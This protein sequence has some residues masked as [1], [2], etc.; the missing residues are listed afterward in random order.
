MAK[1][2]KTTD[3]GVTIQRH[4]CVS[5]FQDNRYGAGNRVFNLGRG[6]M[7]CTSCGSVVKTA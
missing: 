3:N 6:K 7:T 1:S 5:E 4:D 2:T